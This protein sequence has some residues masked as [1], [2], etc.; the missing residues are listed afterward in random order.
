MAR[1][2]LEM[3]KS[4]L[5]VF[6]IPIR[7]TDMN[8]GNHVGNDSIVSII[9][10]ARMQF[11]KQ[12]HCTETDVFGTALIMS[13]LQVEFKSEAFYGDILDVKIYPGEMSKVGF[14][15]LYSL[16]TLRNDTPITV[17][18]AKTG[19]VCFNYN[20]KKIEPLPAELRSALT[21]N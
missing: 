20:K 12:I 1:L 2:K 21:G 9:H 11:L 5:G 14:E 7:I 19:M 6:S 17:A 18:H 16:A 3:P 4:C 8:Y 13:E 15:L 10:E